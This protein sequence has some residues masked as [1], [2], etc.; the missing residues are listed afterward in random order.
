MLN[1]ALRI[2]RECDADITGLRYSGKTSGSGEDGSPEKR[3]GRS[4]FE[5]GIRDYAL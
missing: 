5:V 4:L 1:D 2:K 3:C